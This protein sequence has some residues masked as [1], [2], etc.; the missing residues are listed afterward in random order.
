MSENRSLLRD[1]YL[2]LQDQYEDFDRRSLTI[3]GWVSAGA[4]I[5]F[6]NGFKTS[7]PFSVGAWLA[8]GSIALCIWYLEARWKQF[9]YAL[10]GRIQELEAHFR[11][12]EP[13][14]FP[15]QMYASW[16]RNY[17]RGHGRS[18]LW[19]AARQDFVML[20]YVLIV[21]I[22]CAGAAAQAIR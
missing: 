3:K 13:E 15:L 14:P 20:P 5:A 22:C 10:A 18:S 7:E 1:E 8:I 17:R 19:A 11:G 4:A 2:K 21:L 6:A 12:E 9:Q 16:F